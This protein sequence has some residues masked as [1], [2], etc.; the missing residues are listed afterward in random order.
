MKTITAIALAVLASPLAAQ[1]GVDAATQDFQQ[2]LEES[3]AE[4]AALEASISPEKV[5]LNRR[6]AELEAELRVAQD[7]RQAVAAERD[8][9][10]VDLGRLQREI[11]SLEDD[12]VF[13]SDVLGQYVTNFGASLHVSERARYAEDLQ[14]AQLAPENANLSEIEVFEAQSALVIRSLERLDEGFGG[15]TFSGT[16]VD[17]GGQVRPGTFALVGPVA[18]FKADD[19]SIAGPALERIDS[20]EPAVVSFA[21]PLDQEAA[22]A[23]VSAGTGVMP[24]D[25]TLGNAKRIEGTQETLVEHVKKGGPV[26]IPIFAMAGIAL[27]V[28]LYKW[29]ALTFTPMPSRRDLDRLYQEVRDGNRKSALERSKAM[30]GPLGRMLQAGV[31]HMREPRE[32]VEEVMYEVIL[33]AR[34]RLNRFLP[35]I[36]ICAASAPLLGLLGTVTGIINTFKMI[37]VY[38][39]GDVKSLSGG[40]SEALIT[41]KF[42]L[43]V[44]IPALLL[45]A[46]L[47]RKAKGAASRMETAAV[48]LVNQVSLGRGHQPVAV[49][50]GESGG[51]AVA[52]D[53]A[54]V[55]EQVN[56]I[57]S[58]ILGPLAAAEARPAAPLQAQPE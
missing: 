43:I 8:R 13:L 21:D 31:E 46:F 38:G 41:T 22:A 33:T 50:V 23:F 32:M 9:N 19:G 16:A 5:R 36:A 7:E 30:K 58:D 6:L 42:G 12:T 56:E 53:P 4:L 55:R 35:F 29:A 25:P 1:Q 27:L 57:L 40:I 45:H 37:N 34:L 47:S 54:A 15:T 44:A 17:E 52:P 24:F 28:A 26:M 51:G 3:L 20:S 10:I 11:T 49:S 2:R 39:S 48:G 18:Y 14:A